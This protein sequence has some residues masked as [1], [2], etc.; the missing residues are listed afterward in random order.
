[1]GV[2]SETPRTGTVD[3][4]RG[5]TG[6]SAPVRQ[7]LA[8]E[9]IEVLTRTVG[10]LQATRSEL[11]Y[12]LS[13]ALDSLAEERKRFAVAVAQHK[14]A[15]AAAQ[16]EA[17][18][19][20]E[21]HRVAN[22]ERA[23]DAVR[24][25]AALRLEVARVERDN[26]ALRERVR[27]LSGLPSLLERRRA[28]LADLRE[29]LSLVVH[30]RKSLRRELKRRAGVLARLRSDLRAARGSVSALERSVRGLERE[31]LVL[32]GEATA[33]A[34]LRKQEA[35]ANRI[36]RKQNVELVRLVDELGEGFHAVLA[37]HRWRLG[38]ALLALPR[39]LLFRRSAPTAPDAMLRLVAEHRRRQQNAVEPLPADREV[40]HG[41]PGGEIGGPHG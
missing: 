6:V 28:H 9:R 13:V 37:S 17:A 36:L 27:Q 11:Q 25:L 7:A 31:T 24:E 38:A 22:G 34:R 8:S 10:E 16:H 18:L 26:E 35:G 14:T 40:A 29:R 5:E 20:E 33:N 32:R 41:K 12:D 4:G 15:L 39:L 3:G 2:S 19:A 30:D 21:R 23:L 1:M